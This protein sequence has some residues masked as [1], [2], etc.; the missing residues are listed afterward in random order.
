MNT[1]NLIR[2]IIS[3]V[4]PFHGKHPTVDIHETGKLDINACCD[5]F[6]E[7]IGHIV[8]IELQNDAKT[9]TVSKI[10]G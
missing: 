4:C 10:N 9:T 6:L 8:N 3:K 2:E 7:Q 1:E 5:E